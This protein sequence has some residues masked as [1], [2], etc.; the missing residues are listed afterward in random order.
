MAE[1]PY[2]MGIDY[3]T[4][5]CRVGIFDRAGEAVAFHG[6]EFGTTYPRPAWA[7]QDPD[8]WT[9]ALVGAVKGALEKSGVA[10]E[11]IAGIGTDSTSATVVAMDENGNHLRPAIL[12]MDVRA[13]DQAERIAATGDPALKYNGFGAVSAEWGLPKVMWLK[14]KEPETFNRARYI[15]DCSDWLTKKLTGEWTNSINQAAS[16]YYHD[17]D[18]GGYPQSLYDAVDASDI[19]EKYPGKVTD[20]GVNVG[21]LTREV[22]EATGLKAGTAVAQGGIDAYM[23]ALGLGVTEPGKIALITGSSHVMIGQAPTAVHGQGF[24]GSYT[25]AMIKGQYT[26]EA[27]Q[28]SSGSIVHWFKTNFAGDARAEAESRGVDIYDVLT[29]QA[30]KVPVGSD[31]LIVLD[32][33]QGNRTPH[34]DPLARGVISGLSLGHGAGHLFRAIIEGICYGTEDI[35]RTMRAHDF[36]PRINVVSGGPAKSELWMQLHADVSNVPMGFTRESEGPVLGSAMLGAVAAGIHADIPGAG[37]EM[38]HTERVLE[39]NAERHE[40]YKFWVDR[41][42]ELYPSVKD[43]QHKVARHVT[44]SGDAVSREAVEA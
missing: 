13:S 17:G 31:G 28:V 16:K 22:A 27:G 41:Y 10:P 38:V 2:L 34:T 19:L 24:W 39:P 30:E 9:S 1:G 40:E 20:L 21:G 43:T 29:E 42:I 32:Y 36:E 37:R 6:V 7:E 25:D 8:E 12:W 33:F 15:A 3:G 23:G 35:F 14:E 18:V 4:G 11:E 26:V 5:G 44:A